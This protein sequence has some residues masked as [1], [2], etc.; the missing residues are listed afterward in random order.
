MQIHSCLRSQAPSR[1]EQERLG[2]T[3][4]KAGPTLWE[5]PGLQVRGSIP[6]GQI[7]VFAAKNDKCYQSLI[8]AVADGKT[9][10]NMQLGGYA[11]RVANMELVDDIGSDNQLVSID[12]MSVIPETWV[13]QALDVVHSH[14]LGL[15]LTLQNARAIY[16]WPQMKSHI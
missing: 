14:H 2:P 6:P 10:D 11:P 12:G 16:W 7:Y 8:Q 4:S 3:D 9:D 1:F 13:S 15:D 5:D